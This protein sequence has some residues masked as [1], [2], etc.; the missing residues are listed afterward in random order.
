MK[1]LGCICF[2]VALSACLYAADITAPGNAIQGV[3]NDNDWPTGEAPM[4][5][6]DNNAGTK[7]LH[8][9]GDTQPSGIRVTPS[10]PQ[11][12]AGG[13]T[14]TTANDAVER[15]P[16]TWELYGSNTSISGPWTLIAKGDIVD[17]KQSTAWPRQTKTTTPIRFVNTAAYDHYQVMFPTIRAAA[18][19]NSM[20]IAE[21]E[22]LE[23][24]A[25]G[26]AP[27]VSVGVDRLVR[28]PDTTVTLT[29][30]ISDFDTPI[31]H[32]HMDPE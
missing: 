18:S 14:F 6:I 25:N 1:S 26:W 7:F 12:I 31:H 22:I 28:I 30:T 23:A 21:I 11:T 3:P 20:Q 24:P 16:I 27:E 32:P 8:F 19:A 15:D 13:M 5:A 10:T 4:Y 2:M 29:G 17:F 9:K